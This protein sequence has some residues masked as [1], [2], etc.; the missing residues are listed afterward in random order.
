[1]SPCPSKR[2]LANPHIRPRG[3]WDRRI[4]LHR[5][6][7][8]HLFPSKCSKSSVCLSGMLAQYCYTPAL[9]CVC[10]LFL[11]LSFNFCDTLC[12]TE[13]ASHFEGQDFSLPLFIVAVAQWIKYCATIRKV[14]GS[15]PDGVMEFFV[16]INPFDRSMALGSTQP[17][18][19]ISTRSV[20][21]GYMR[22]V[23]KADNLTTILCRFREIWEP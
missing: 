14:A 6:S 12:F 21:W 16:D 23:R 20:S 13:A 2:A 3:N 5:Q 11:L 10:R 19:E 1:L 15:I 4:S 17:L 9:I 22:P 8:H 18:I 7:R